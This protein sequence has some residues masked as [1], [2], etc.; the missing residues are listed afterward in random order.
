MGVLGSFEALNRGPLS[1]L[2]EDK[3]GR[4]MI[5]PPVTR[6]LDRSLRSGS[7]PVSFTADNVALSSR[8]PI[9]LFGA[10]ALVYATMHAVYT[11]TVIRCR[12]L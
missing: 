11:A 3:R 8:D 12:L 4:F 7:G 5:R 10:G 1:F 2:Y 6:D 9:G